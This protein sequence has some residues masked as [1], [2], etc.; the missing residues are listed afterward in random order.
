M[1]PMADTSPAAGSAPLNGWKEI[2]AYLGRSVRAVQRYEREL[3]LPVHRLR[4]ADGQTVYA[5]RHDIDAWRQTHDSQPADHQPRSREATQTANAAPKEIPESDPPESGPPV[6]PTHVA[7]RSRPWVW[8]TLCVVLAVTGGLAVRLGF[9]GSISDITPTAFTLVGHALEARDNN[10]RLAWSHDFGVDVSQAPG[11]PSLVVDLDD[12]GSPE[13]TVP[14]RF[15]LLGQLGTRSDALY[16]FSRDGQIR[17]SV[18]AQDWLTCG[19]ETFSGPWQIRAF[20]SSKGPGPRTSWVSFVHHTWWPSVVLEIEPDGAQRIRYA[21]T[22][23]ITALAEWTPPS[24]S[25]LAAGGV[26][27]EQ[28]QPIVALVDLGKAPAMTPAIDKRFSCDDLPTAEP[29][30]VFLLPIP[31]TVTAR[32]L[33][34]S[35]VNKIDVVGEELKIAVEAKEGSEIIRLRADLTV[36]DVAFSDTFWSTHRELELQG[37]IRHSAEK[38][39][40]RAEQIVRRWM[41]GTDWQDLKIVPTLRSPQR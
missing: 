19:T 13:V 41:P 28:E 32:N 12:D 40:S 35:F 2:A 15:G 3:G 30:A 33:P 29:S 34:Y 4:T 25:Y 5:F 6:A 11:G 18:T 21:Q 8:V 31:E 24:G 26:T 10:G 22:G 7:Q 20:L 9:F 38:C 17:W 39:S 36:A 14:V 37:K 16:A 1:L 27:N 23:W